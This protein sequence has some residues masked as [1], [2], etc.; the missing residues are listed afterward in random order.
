MDVVSSGKKEKKQKNR[1]SDVSESAFL[2]LFKIRFDSGCESIFQAT[3][4]SLGLLPTLMCSFN[5]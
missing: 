5:D 1:T 4:E 3:N 2:F